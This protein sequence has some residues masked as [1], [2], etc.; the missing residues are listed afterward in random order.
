MRRVPPLLAN[1]QCYTQ[2]AATNHTSD[3][4]QK[5]RSSVV[6]HTTALCMRHTS[7]T[8]QKFSAPQHSSM[9]APHTH[10]HAHAHAPQTQHRSAQFYASTKVPHNQISSYAQMRLKFLSFCCTIRTI[11]L[12]IKALLRVVHTIVLQFSRVGQARVGEV[13][14]NMH[15]TFVHQCIVESSSKQ[16]KYYSSVVQQS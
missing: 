5:H 11:H 2:P 12:Y 1:R 14:D 15:N 8:A 9:H 13:G 3:T 16:Q 4:E 6:Q 7:D 10:A